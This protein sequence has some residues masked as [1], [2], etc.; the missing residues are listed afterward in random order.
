MKQL[1]LYYETETHLFVHAN[2]DPD[3]PLDEQDRRVLLWRGLDHVPG[4]HSSGKRALVGHT[5]QLSRRILD[6]GYLKCLD[7]GC[8][9][10]GLLTAL[11]VDNE[12][13]WQVDER[14]NSVV[15]DD[16]S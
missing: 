9:E 13:V 16:L 15:L 5:P 12:Q 6:L 4:P 14:G 10:G 8:G 2:Y 11:D 7:T 1:R 3:L